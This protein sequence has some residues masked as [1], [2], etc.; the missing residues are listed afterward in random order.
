MATPLQ[1]SND[2]FDEKQVFIPQETLDDP[3]DVILVAENGKEFK[4]HK[5]VLS[6]ASAFFAKL[7][8]IDMRESRE[9]KA[10][11]ETVG[12][13][14]LRDVLEFIYTG[15]VQISAEDNAME[16][17]T[18]A[19]YL[20]LP[21]LVDLVAKWLEHNLNISNC[22]LSYY[23]AERYRCENLALVSKKCILAH[24]TLVAKTAEF[25][26]VS[27]EDL[28][29]WISRVDLEVSSEDDVFNAILFWISGNKLERS[30]YFAQLFRQVRLPYV[31]RGCLQSDVVTNEFVRANKFCLNLVK[32]TIKILVSKIN[33]PFVVK[34]R[35]SLATPVVVFSAKKGGQILCYFP[36]EDTWRTL[37]DWTPAFGCGDMF[38]SHGRLYFVR[39]SKVGPEILRYDSFSNSWESLPFTEQR[40]LSQIFVRNDDV[41]AL[42]WDDCGCKRHHS[43]IIKYDTKANSWEKVCSFDLRKREGFCI[44][45]K[46]N[47]IYLLGGGV[48]Q[49]G[50]TLKDKSN[51]NAD[52]YDLKGDSWEKIADIRRY[53]WGA[54]GAVAHGKI[55]VTGGVMRDC[56]QRNL[57]TRS[58]LF[59]VNYRCEGVEGCEVYDES[60]D[61]WHNIAKLTVPR[62]SSYVQRK[63]ICIDG[64]LCVLGVYKNKAMGQIESYDPEKN[65]WRRKTDI[66]LR[67]MFDVDIL[68]STNMTVF[69]GSKFIANGLSP[70]AS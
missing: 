23:C 21:H 12:E 20:F 61:E 68:M 48:Y 5:S 46:D 56:D 26:N 57:N 19:D 59:G 50:T 47:F 66:P 41:F 4:A 27:A 43:T 51:H 30:K 54:Q 10:R 18:V 11:L 44:V 49:P 31:S 36:R 7:L 6:S 15:S 58:R 42:V 1:S 53:K 3:C 8:N 60:T 24:F 34:P 55:Y 35:K 39:S 16:L 29:M 14:A 69:T 22:I 65:E 37:R 2:S 52:R 64:Q 28:Q 40:R 9:G 45:A 62:C 63:M 38:S 25:V 17:I 13:A 33:Y 32:G 70:L 67:G